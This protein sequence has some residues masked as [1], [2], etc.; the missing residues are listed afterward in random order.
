MKEADI[1]SALTNQDLFRLSGKGKYT[2]N[3]AKN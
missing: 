3:F 1:T 2:Y